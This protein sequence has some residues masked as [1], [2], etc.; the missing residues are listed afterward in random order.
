M[1]VEAATDIVG[2]AQTSVSNYYEYFRD[3]VVEKCGAEMAV[4]EADDVQI[5]ESLFGRRTYNR[6][7][8][9]QD[10]WVFGMC[11]SEPGGKIFVTTV[12]D[13]SRATLEPIILSR[14]PDDAVVYSDL[15][16]AYA[17][18]GTQNRQH[19]TVNHS[20]NFVDPGTG[21]YPAN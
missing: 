7:C 11:E 18:L 5:D 10:Q 3:R 16:R 4:W 17:N 9:V 20:R 21:T 6:G 13:R 2:V 8:I 14:T 12:T 1:P 15:W 19:M